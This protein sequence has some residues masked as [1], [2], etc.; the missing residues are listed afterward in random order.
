MSDV[1]VKVSTPQG[2]TVGY[3]INPKLENICQE[4]FQISGTFV[5]EEG[6]ILEKIDFNPQVVPY[7]VDLCPLSSEK[8]RCLINAYVQ[9][10]RQPVIMTGVCRN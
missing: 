3:F 1:K 4:D 5:D 10:G 6:R 7:T 9:R 8:S 2:T